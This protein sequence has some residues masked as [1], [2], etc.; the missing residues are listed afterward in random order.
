MVE[1]VNRDASLGCTRV[2]QRLTV[3]AGFFESSVNLGRRVEGLIGYGD[4]DRS[5][6]TKVGLGGKSK[7]G[8]E[9]EFRIPWWLGVVGDARGSRPADHR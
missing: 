6:A 8:H 5:R 9:C 7:A 3:Q 1:A 2:E 4:S